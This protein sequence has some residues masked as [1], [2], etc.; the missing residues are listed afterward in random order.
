MPRSAPDGRSLVGL[1]WSGLPMRL[2]LF[3]DVN[4]VVVDV[5]VLSTNDTEDLVEQVR[6]MFLATGFIPARSNGIDV[7]SYKDLE[8]SVDDLR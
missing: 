6:L 8:L 7:A 5:Q 1:R 2:R 3:I 4:G